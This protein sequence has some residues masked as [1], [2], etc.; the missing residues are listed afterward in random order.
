V[1]KYDSMR[2]LERNSLLINYRKRHPEANL[3]QIGEIFGISKQR[4][5][6]ILK[7]NDK[8]LGLGTTAA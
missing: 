1:A 2:K 5:W 4:V 8:P 7:N 6:E 3:S